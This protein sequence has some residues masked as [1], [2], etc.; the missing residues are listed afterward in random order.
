MNKSEE[1]P[2]EKIEQNTYIKSNPRLIEV[3]D[4]FMLKAEK[5]VKHQRWGK[6]MQSLEFVSIGLNHIKEPLIVKVMSERVIAAADKVTNVLVNHP[7]PYNQE[8]L[9]V[10]LEMMQ[11]FR[12]SYAKLIDNG[13]KND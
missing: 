10:F 7:V 13:E 9:A 6:A 8:T 11:D 3:V 2:E 12:E 1:A 5:S 4:F